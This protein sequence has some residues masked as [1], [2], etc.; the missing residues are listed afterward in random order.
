[1]LTTTQE[2]INCDFCWVTLTT[3]ANIYIYIAHRDYVLLEIEYLRNWYPI[4]IGSVV[5]VGSCVLLKIEDLSNWYPITIGSVV[6]VGSLCSIR[7]RRFKKLISYNN[8]KCSVSKKLIFIRNRITQPVV[9][10]Y[11]L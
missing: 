4:T 10:I 8:W 7:N 6:L 2:K 5:L 1:M 3:Y 11:I 9:S